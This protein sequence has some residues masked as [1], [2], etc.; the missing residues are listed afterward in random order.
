MTGLSAGCALHHPQHS[1]PTPVSHT[2]VFMWNTYSRLELNLNILCEIIEPCSNIQLFHDV[3][4]Q[5]KR[6]PVK[7]GLMI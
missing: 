5:F 2:V 1:F 4:G 6:E 7:A 3:Y